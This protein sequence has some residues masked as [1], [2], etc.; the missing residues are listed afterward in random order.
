MN[1]KHTHGIWGIAEN[2]IAG[3]SK[4]QYSILSMMTKS[5]CEVTRHNYRQVGGNK[6]KDKNTLHLDEEA[7][8]NAI[9]IASAPDLL[10]A[11]QGLIKVARGYELLHQ[12]ENHL[13]KKLAKLNPQNR[14]S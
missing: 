9:L 6:F 3:E 14:C 10:D 5:V 11:L 8:A 2:H 4:N 12:K 7:Q 13:S 1:T